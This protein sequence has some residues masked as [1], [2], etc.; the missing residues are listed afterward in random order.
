MKYA[1]LNAQQECIN[2]VDWDGESLWQPPEGCTAVL[3]E[4]N[5]YKLMQPEKNQEEINL[6]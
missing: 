1:I 5:K 6:L 3:N 2:I 4:D